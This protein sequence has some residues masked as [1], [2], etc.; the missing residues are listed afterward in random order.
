MANANV[1]KT[2]QRMCHRQ[3][4]D[5]A[6][7]AAGQLYESLMGDDEFYREWRRQNPRLDAKGLERAFINQNWAKCIE[8]ARSTLTLML[9]RD[10]I[11]EDVKAEI[12]V[13]LEQD[14]SIRNKHVRPTDPPFGRLH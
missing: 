3:V 5:V 6:M 12:M 8:F 7:A 2:G 10:D 4:R 13:V 9:T 1:S 14:Q 11:S